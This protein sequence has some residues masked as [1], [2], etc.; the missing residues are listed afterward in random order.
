MGYAGRT[1]WHAR[2]F[3]KRGVGGMHTRATPKFKE[4]GEKQWPKVIKFLHKFWL[5]HYPKY[6]L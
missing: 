3:A 5:V 2:T 6:N 4:K 1:L